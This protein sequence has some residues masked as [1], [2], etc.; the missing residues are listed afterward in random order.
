MTYFLDGVQYSRGFVATD[1]GRSK[2]QRSRQRNDCAVRALAQAASVDY[3]VAYDVLAECGRKCGRGTA[4]LLLIDAI[5]KLDLIWKRQ[6]F[7]AVKG[8]RRTP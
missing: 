7:P 2:S 3:D 1:A 8:Q 4:E 5:Q 6:T